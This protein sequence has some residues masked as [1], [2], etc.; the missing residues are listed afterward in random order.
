MEFSIS[1]EGDVADP[2]I[3][4]HVR[5]WLASSDGIR[6]LH[7][8]A[9]SVYRC[10]S[11]YRIY[12]RFFNPQDPSDSCIEE[13]QSE[14]ARFILESDG[15]RRG[16]TCTSAFN[17]GYLRQ[18]FIHRCIDSARV[19]G[20]DDFR[21]LYRAMNRVCRESALFVVEKNRHHPCRFSMKPDSLVIPPLAEEDL[22]DIEFPHEL[23]FDGW[24]NHITHK[25]FLLPVLQYFWESLR[26]LWDNCPVWIELRA[27]AHWLMR[28]V[29]TEGPRQAYFT[30]EAMADAP[31]DEDLTTAGPVASLQFHFR[32]PESGS[33]F[34]P[35]QV[36]RWAL[37]FPKHLSDAKNLFF[38]FGTVLRWI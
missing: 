11:L 15:M 16:L 18:S 30:E 22:R 31:G 2:A 19:S 21:I 9:K 36:C 24:L 34:D 26:R 32:N 7:Q 6:L 23:A 20:N 38:T 13:I 3:Q 37:I 8:A 27:A 35:D 17:A 29:A 33:W 14:L 4:N 5:D 25:R 10:L 12:P 1:Q 28:F